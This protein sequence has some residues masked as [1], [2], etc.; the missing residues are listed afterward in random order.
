MVSEFFGGKTLCLDLNPDEAVAYGAAVQGSIISSESSEVV[1]IDVYPLT[2]G[3]ETV[4]GVMSP[5]IPRNTRIPCEKK[6]HYTTHSDD[7]AGARIEIFEGERKM[8]RDNRVLGV[9]ALHRLP[10]AP[11]GQLRICVTFAIDANAI[12]TVSAEE[13]TTK[14]MESIQIDTLEFALS[15]SQVDEAI[16]SASAFADEDEQDCQRVVARVEYEGAILDTM[17]TLQAEEGNPM[18]G[19]SLIEELQKK[20]KERQ[21]WLEQHPMESGDLYKKKAEELR[22]EFSFLF[23]V[24]QLPD[25]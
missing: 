22:E 25:L 8:T 19:K 3:V 20:L 18:Y 5:I 6:R 1:V 2:L 24:G 23:H 14:T 9:F 13:L 4:G 17:R 15:Q 21:S 10:R 7:A 16:E 12:L 11:R